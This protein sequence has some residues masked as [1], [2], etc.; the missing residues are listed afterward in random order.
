M[1]K[2]FN[3]WN[4]FDVLLVFRLTFFLIFAENI[5]IYL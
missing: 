2:Y 5:S 1:L 3:H 4:N